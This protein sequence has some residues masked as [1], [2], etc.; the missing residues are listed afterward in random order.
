MIE[1]EMEIQLEDRLKALAAR[2]GMEPEPYILMMLELI[3]KIGTDFDPSRLP[4]S[5]V[6]SRAEWENQIEKFIEEHP[7]RNRPEPGPEATQREVTYEHP[8]R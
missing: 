6:G 3:A 4:L 5:V 1:L 7:A 2:R 8:E